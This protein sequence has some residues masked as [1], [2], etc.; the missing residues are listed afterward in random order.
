MYKKIAIT[1]AL[2]ILLLG[3]AVLAPSATP[4]GWAVVSQQEFSLEG[5]EGLP[6]SLSPDGTWLLSIGQEHGLCLY[7]AVDLSPRDC[8]QPEVEGSIWLSQKA[9]AWA[10]EGR[11]LAFGTLDGRL[12][13]LEVEEGQ[14]AW[15]PSSVTG[16]PPIPA[17]SP[18]GESLAVG[19]GGV[20]VVAPPGALAEAPV[21]R[22]EG[23]LAG[24]RWANWNTLIY[25]LRTPDRKSFQLWQVAADGS[26]QPELLWSDPYPSFQLQA[27]S[28]DGRFAWVSV[29]LVDL[30][31][32]EWVPVRGEHDVPS[33]AFSPDGEWWL[34]VYRTVKN[35]KAYYVLAVRPA[36]T[37]EEEEQ[38]LLESPGKQIAILGWASTD[39]VALFLV[40]TGNYGLQFLQLAPPSVSTLPLPEEAYGFGLAWAPDGSG[41]V[42]LYFQGESAVMEW[43]DLPSGEVRWQ[44]GDLEYPVFFETTRP[45]AFSPAGDELALGERSRVRFLAAADG[46]TRGKIE[47]EENFR[48]LALTYRPD[49]SLA[50]VTSH[51]DRWEPPMLASPSVDLFLELWSRSGSLQERIELGKRV[52]PITFSKAS[53]SKDGSVLVYSAGTADDPSTDPWL[54]H[55]M[56]VATGETQAWDLREIVPGLREVGLRAQITD[57]VL[58]PDG[59]EVAVGLFSADEG[60]PLVLRLDAETGELLGQL[61]PSTG[62][63]WLVGELAYSPDGRF[64]A[65]SAYSALT[66]EP[67]SLALVDLAGEDPEVTFLCQGRPGECYVLSPVFSPDGTVLATIYQEKII[68]WEIKE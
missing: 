44:V 46:T 32:G 25:G 55:R 57:L 42:A 34:Y 49:G 31:Q 8:Y 24:L 12:W 40:A 19:S 11:R 5:V 15:L 28:P 29:G 45:M 62:R 1:L 52:L 61:F 68:L 67:A 63:E 36:G 3:W 37:P 27:L 30:E 9:I 43:R 2:A 4:T 16:E 60:Q 26:G 48:P 64:L 14:L 20:I 65:V 59:K 23:I 58:R 54:I 7:R 56:D 50:M 47:L 33:F 6:H 41:L 21:A 35:L 51:A 38:V 17:W 39:L 13:L 18:D 10:P 22:Y 66:S 53:F